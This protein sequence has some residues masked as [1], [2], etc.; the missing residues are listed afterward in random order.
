MPRGYMV[1][2]TVAHAARMRQKKMKEEELQKA[3]SKKN[4]KSEERKEMLAGCPIG[5]STAKSE[6][7][8]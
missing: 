7:G 6:F 2:A 5:E 3:K 4:Q 8:S 1:N